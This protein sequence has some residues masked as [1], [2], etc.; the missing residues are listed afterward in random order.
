M[1]VFD[2]RSSGTGLLV[3]LGFEDPT[4]TADALERVGLWRDGRPVDEP[5]GAV[6]TAL[7]DVA[8][9]DL[10]LA[11]LVR[12]VAAAPDAEDLR[13]VLREETGLRRRLLGVLGTSVALGDHLVAHPADWHALQGD[14]GTDPDSVRPTLWSRQAALL[15]AV[16]ADPSV[17]TW[18]SGGARA[19][20]PAP[21]AVE[22]LRA[23]YRRC[24]LELAARDATG[25]VT[26]EEVGAEMADLASATLSAGLAVAQ[27]GLP[28]DAAPCRLAVIGM[29]KA[30]GRELNYVSD[31]DVVF[32]AEAVDGPS[33]AGSADAAL[34]SATR[35]ASEMMRVCGE[36]AWPVDAGLRP[37]GGAGPL[38]RTLASHEAYYRRW[39]S[40]WE[41]QALLKARPLAGDLA[42]GRAYVDVVEPLVWRASERKG[43]VEDVQ[44]MRRRVEGTLKGDRAA[45]EVKLGPGGLRDVEFAV[46]LLQLVHGK[47]DEGVRSGTTLV[48][49]EQLA[50]GG[51]VGR[52]DARHLAEAYRWLRTVE[53]RLQLHRLRRTHLLPAAD[54]EAGL[55]R[56]ARAVGYRK[57]VLQTFGRERAGYG[58]EVRRLHEKLFYRPLLTAVARLPADQARLTP[59]AAK[60]RL[61]A[62]G[63]AEPAVALRHLEALTGG[64]SRRAVIQQTLLPAMLGWFADAADPDAGLKSFRSV[65]DALGG[66]PWYLR[67]LRD[68]GQAAERLAHLLASSRYVA[69]LLGRAPEAVRLLASDEE[70]R[71]RPREVLE[72]AFVQVAR[73]REDWEGTVAAARGM[74]REELL[75]VACADALGL[76]DLETVG[77]ALSDV[78][79]AVLAAALETAT[80]KVSS[81]RRGELPVRMAVLA[82][83][84]LGGREQGYGSDAD[85][86]F[87][88]EALPGTAEADAASAAHDVAHEVRRLLALPAPDPPLVVD[89]DL[90][91]EGKQGPL[92]RSLASYAAY[93]AR[94]SHVWES[95][96]LLRAAPLVG[97]ADL[98]DRFLAAVDPVRHPAGGPTTEQVREIRRIKARMERERMPRGVDPKL[99]PK[100]G[101]G[102]LADVEWVV[103]LLQ[104]RHAFEVEALRTPSTLPALH[105]AR[106]A[107]LLERDDAEVLE[108]AWTLTARVRDA[109][110]LVRGKPA[111][112]LPS[113]G[114]ELDGVA[115]SLGYPPTS[116]GDFLD[117]YRR[118]TRRARAVFERVF[119]E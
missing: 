8:D 76:L 42:L 25:S 41:F 4:S 26:V 91:P 89:A 94:W 48:A 7:A 73:R 17:P 24:V 9:P 116:Q 36:V 47:A 43:F 57:D 14:P 102:G 82:M 12:L 103:Q 6:V 23:A 2:S 105:A 107:G 19:S 92:S 56:L 77:G 20:V 79:A 51:Y 68:E 114:R 31:V 110:V 55:R 108:A 106:D 10:A 58:H 67:L 72:R 111:V 28:D 60:E 85:V 45:R 11:A 81:E 115:R 54:D 78:A 80:R 66:T 15:A 33:S 53:H 90:R 38:V 13:R 87:V 32:V 44:A 37:E 113:S 52:E 95:Q 71:P 84:R 88:H 64:V 35:L 93:Y 22:A 40:T 50:A 18:G 74:R 63:F 59:A 3:R 29:G 27:A 65:S 30:G 49:L 83:G 86:L 97:D 61:E 46:Q 16:G 34:R 109:L 112:S 100:L 75:R 118:A 119:Y 21:Q 96:A 117:D 1:S 39:A 98:A 62:L 70:L 104:L 99:V 69:D 101:P 5:A